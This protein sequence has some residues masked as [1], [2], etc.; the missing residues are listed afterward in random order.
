MYSSFY[1]G[2]TYINI[3]IYNKVVSV[4][5]GKIKSEDQ[6]EASLFGPICGVYFGY[7]SIDSPV[8][9]GLNILAQYTPFGDMNVKQFENGIIFNEKKINLGFGLKV[10]VRF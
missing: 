6:V 2:L 5:D 10:G 4:F 8:F 1:L 9:I 3:D 7:P